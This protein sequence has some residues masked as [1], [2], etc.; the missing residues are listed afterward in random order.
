VS[1]S[2]MSGQLFFISISESIACSPV[3]IG[4]VLFGKLFG[5]SS[6]SGTDSPYRPTPNFR[7][8]SASS[9]PNGLRPTPGKH[10]SAA[11]DAARLKCFYTF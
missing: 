10:D 7:R 11:R 5:W 9:Q 8:L 6:R 3:D 4:G 2:T 1:H